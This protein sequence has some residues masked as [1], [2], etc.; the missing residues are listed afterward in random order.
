MNEPLSQRANGTEEDERARS[1]KR[2]EEFVRLLGQNQRWL[3]IYVT[4]L[5]P[6]WS[7]TEEVIQETNLV[8]WRE[9]DRFE[10]GTNFTAW[11]FRVALNQVL[12]WRKRRRRD[13]LEFSPAFLEVVAAATAADV[14]RLEERPGLRRAAWKSCRPITGRCF[15]YGT[16]KGATFRR[17]RAR[18]AARLM[19][20]TAP[21]TGSGMP[22]IS[23]FRVPPRRE[24][25][26]DP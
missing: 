20:S 26:H 6:V 23:V 19:P 17:P 2:V 11:A 16:A 5:V 7:D 4:S 8:L 15:S 14:E 25:S 10:S 12:A 18:S 22:S 13:R 21:S 1:P 24:V 9:F 3:L